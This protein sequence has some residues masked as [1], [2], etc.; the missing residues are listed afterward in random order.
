MRYPC[1][2]AANKF[3]I[4]LASAASCT[5]SKGKS[6]ATLSSPGKIELFWIWACDYSIFFLLFLFILFVSPLSLVYKQLLSSQNAVH[7]L[8]SKKSKAKARSPYL[9]LPICFLLQSWC[10]Q[11]NFGRQ[12]G[13]QPPLLPSLPAGCSLPQPAAGEL[14]WC[15][16]AGNLA[17]TPR[18]PCQRCWLAKHLVAFQLSEASQ[19]QFCLG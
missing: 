3:T 15:V 2:S 11:M 13:R 6:E 16:S 4:S 8:F 5:P 10:W 7:K 12:A 14:C 1:F 9:L 19:R 17:P 18:L